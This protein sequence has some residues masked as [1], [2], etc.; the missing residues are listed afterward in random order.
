MPRKRYAIVGAGSRH[1]MFRDA[2]VGRFGEH[3][4]LVAL[5]DSNEG[6]MRLSNRQMA[7]TGHPGVATY[8]DADFDRL[9]AEAKPDVIVV[10]TRDSFHDKYIVRAMELGAGD[11]L[12]RGHEGLL[13]ARDRRAVRAFRAGRALP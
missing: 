7:E 10:T 9:V 13:H 8:S 11:G 12:R 6:R 4:E 5:C 1:T 3:C 2:I